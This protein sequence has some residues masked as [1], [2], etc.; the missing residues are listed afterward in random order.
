[1]LAD[2]V[3]EVEE[4]RE[5]SALVV[6][7][8]HEECLGIVHLECVQIQHHLAAEAAAVDVVAQEEV[9][10]VLRVAAHL[11]QS[12]EVEEL[13]VQVSA[14]CDGILQLQH[15]GL[16]AQQC[17]HAADEVGGQVGRHAALALEVLLEDGQVGEAGALV[18]ELVALHGE[19]GR[20]DHVFHHSVHLHHR[21]LLVVRGGHGSGRRRGH[22]E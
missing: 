2:L 3:L 18:D 7:T 13:P 4:R 15:V 20:G 12:N 11:E 10:C 6:A 21:T 19:H 22:G 8:Q 5:L 9:L 17:G 1:M 14:H 16:V